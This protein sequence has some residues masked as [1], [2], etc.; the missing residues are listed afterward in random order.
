MKRTLIDDLF[1]V[2]R[3][4]SCEPN[5]DNIFYYHNDNIYYYY[6]EHCK[7]GKICVM[8]ED[9]IKSIKKFY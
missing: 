9:L 5:K 1:Q 3:S 8:V 7:N 2:S 4:L 6:C